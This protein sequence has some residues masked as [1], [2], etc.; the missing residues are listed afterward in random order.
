MVSHCEPGPPH[1][2][3]A[4]FGGRQVTWWRHI[5]RGRWLRDGRRVTQTDK[6]FASWCWDAIIWVHFNVLMRLK[7]DACLKNAYKTA[8]ILI[9]QNQFIASTINA[10][11][12]LRPWIV[13]CGVWKKNLSI[14]KACYQLLNKAKMYR[15]VN[16]LLFCLWFASFLHSRFYHTKQFDSNDIQNC[17]YDIKPNFIF[18]KLMGSFHIKMPLR[19]IDRLIGFSRIRLRMAKYDNPQTMSTHHWRRWFPIIL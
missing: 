3:L 5:E 11:E 18:T 9:G 14:F 17:F 13:L 8:K 7:C 1:G 4:F 12:L 15:S 6:L 16:I 2:A 10:L 19:L